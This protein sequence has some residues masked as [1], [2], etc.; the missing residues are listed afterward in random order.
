MEDEEHNGLGDVDFSGPAH[1]DD[2]H[3][4]GAQ[5]GIGGAT[6]CAHGRHDA[7]MNGVGADVATGCTRD[8]FGHEPYRCF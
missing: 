3:A 1:Q 4:V 7:G 8:R 6:G 5:R 2:A